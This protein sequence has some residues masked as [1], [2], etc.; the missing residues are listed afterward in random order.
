MRGGA[1][2][3]RDCQLVGSDGTYW[4][5]QLTSYKDI[6]TSMAE[7]RARRVAQSSAVAALALAG[8]VGALALL[9][10]CSGNGKSSEAG[11]SDAGSLDAL[12]AQGCQPD[13]PATAYAAGAGWEQP[14]VGRRRRGADPVLHAHGDGDVRELH[15]D[16][17]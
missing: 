12:A 7:A 3:Q 8:A 6:G 5:N 1:V 9:G 14:G 13:R 2:A 16:R 15:R 4:S 10:A 17:A 11:A